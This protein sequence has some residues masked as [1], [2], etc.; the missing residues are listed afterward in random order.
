MYAASGL[1]AN[2]ILRS[3]C[4][5]A[6]PLFIKIAIDN[7]GVE[8]VCTIFGCIAVLLAPIPLFFYR[9]GARLRG[10]SSFAPCIVSY[11]GIAVTDVRISKLK[12]RWTQRHP[13]GR[14]KYT[15]HDIDAYIYY[16]TFKHY[17]TW[18]SARSAFANFWHPRLSPVDNLVT[19]LNCL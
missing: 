10:N 17:L 12:R 14:Y 1:A 5:A 16:V 13:R 7:I 19:G 4:G 6:F 9:Y 3:A 11:F 18:A 15:N 8:W 2:T